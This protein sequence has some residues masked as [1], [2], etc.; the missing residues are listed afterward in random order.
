MMFPFMFPQCKEFSQTHEPTLPDEV[1][2][3]VV[4]QFLEHDRKFVIPSIIQ[5]FQKGDEFPMIL[6]HFL[7][8]QSIAVVA[9]GRHHAASTPTTSSAAA[10][11]S[12]TSAGTSSRLSFSTKRF[13]LAVGLGIS[14]QPEGWPAPNMMS[15][16][17]IR[18]VSRFSRTPSSR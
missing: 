13:S 2:A 16:S 18:S 7:H 1:Q 8:A 14:A 17:T 11:K 3:N 15:E 4:H 5:D 10:R 6:V 9:P 12:A